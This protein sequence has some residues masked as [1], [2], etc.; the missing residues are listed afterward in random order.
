MPD[1]IARDIG[2]TSEPHRI[3]G[4]HVE[5]PLRVL[6]VGP[7]SVED[8][9]KTMG[10]VAVHVS[11]LA[12]KLA[13]LGHDVA[14]YA[15]NLPADAP[16]RTEWGML[17]SRPARARLW[18]IALTTN[19][20][21]A[22][23]RRAWSG[24][25][26]SR[27]CGWKPD[28][29]LAHALGLRQ[30]LVA[31]RPDV[32]HYHH[33]EIRPHYGNMAGVDVPT[34]ITTHSLSAFR[35]AEKHC[36]QKLAAENL[37]RADLVLA[38]S[39]DAAEAFAELVSGVA[40]RFVPN[41]IDIDAFSEDPGA[42]PEGLPDGTPLVLYVGW[43]AEHKGVL[44]LVEAV[45][46]LTER[47]DDIALAIVGPEIDLTVDRIR[48][49]WRGDTARL[50]VRT[51]VGRDEIVRWLH[52]ADLFVLPSTVREGQ[53][54]VIIEAFAAGTPVVATDVGAVGDLVEHGRLA[55]LAP[56]GDP[57]ELAEAIEQALGDRV[58]AR[59]RAHLAAE[60]AATFDSLGVTALVVRAYRDAIRAHASDS[61]RHRTQAPDAGSRGAHK[62]HS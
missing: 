5:G 41:G 23:A 36:Q 19:G 37:R 8:G 28:N 57:R 62:E 45:S 16:K 2:T 49:G 60:K 47:V 52:A 11:E 6:L 14:V 29:I 59:E 25:A 26:R 17:F 3:A 10:G 42:M 58:A 44:D 20:G 38:V 51:A 9:G 13:E 46:Q 43:L 56:P 32:V 35:D 24:R 40:P 39:P 33:A 53:S 31:H 18:P 21:I 30:A 4:E 50:S 55:L 1:M 15:D 12:R 34:V 27:A 48:S 7:V 61:H 54:R 22:T